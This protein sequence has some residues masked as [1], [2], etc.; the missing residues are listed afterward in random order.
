[1]HDWVLTLR[2]N[3]NCCGQTIGESS[4]AGGAFCWAV[5][6]AEDIM[7]Q[8]QM[9]LLIAEWHRSVTSAFGDMVD[10]AGVSSCPQCDVPARYNAKRKEG[11]CAHVL[12]S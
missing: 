4:V 5:V 8:V 3:R 7:R 12:W 9:K 2:L 11:V 1:M 6:V 10:E